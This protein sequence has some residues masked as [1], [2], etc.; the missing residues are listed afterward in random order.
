MVAVLNN[1]GGF[2][3]RALYVHELQK[4]GAVL[5]L[6]C[7]NHSDEVVNISGVD[8]YLGLVGTHGLDGKLIESIPEER[9]Q[10]GLYTG[11]GGPAET[12]RPRPGTGH[13]PDPGGRLT[14]YR[15]KQKR[16][17]LAGPSPAGQECQ[18]GK[19]S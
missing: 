10:N 14:L 3:N 16:T 5:H 6:P 11:L 12:D 17:A 13:H 8:A 7:V 15:S 2:Y 9:R 4:A 18:N 1:Y 19:F